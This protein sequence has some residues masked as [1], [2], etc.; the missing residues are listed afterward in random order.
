M[1][2]QRINNT[3]IWS[4]RK[5]LYQT[6]AD[7][8]IGFFLKKPTCFILKPIRSVYDHHTHTRQML[9]TGISLKGH[10]ASFLSKVH[11]CW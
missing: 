7:L 8:F 6:A 2:N 5:L 4:K 11:V 9:Y 10:S 1:A 3:E